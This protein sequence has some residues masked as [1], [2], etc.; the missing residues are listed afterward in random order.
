[1]NLFYCKIFLYY[2]C[3]WKYLFKNPWI[4]YRFDILYLLPDQQ[5][6]STC[7]PGSSLVPRGGRIPRPRYTVT[8]TPWSMCVSTTTPA[9]RHAQGTRSVSLWCGRCR[10]PTWTMACP[11]YP[12][13]AVSNDV[14]ILVLYPRGKSLKWGSRESLLLR[15]IIGQTKLA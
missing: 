6:S 13:G 3:H 8:K 14:F 9:R 1:M 5:W 15:R 10:R 4:Q 2:S 12:T 7:C 11:T